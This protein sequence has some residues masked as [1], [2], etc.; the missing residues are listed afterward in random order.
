[1]LSGL[2]QLAELLVRGLVAICCTML[3]VMTVTISALVFTRYVLDYSFPWA[4]ELTR[5]LLVWL[6]MLAVAVNQFRNENIRVDFIVALAPERLRALIYLI[7]RLLIIWFSFILIYYGWTMAQNM[8]ITHSAA[9]GLSM[10]I[11]YL[12]IPVGAVLLALFSLANLI[13]DIREMRGKQPLQSN[14]AKA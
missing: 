13:D 4:E 11:P 1:M 14:R 10:R 12:A 9:L 2:F 6:V 5:Y 8:T 3:G 7:H